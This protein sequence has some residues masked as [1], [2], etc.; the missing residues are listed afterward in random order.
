MNGIHDLGGMDGLGPIEPQEDEPVFAADWERR[1]FALSVAMGGQM[2]FTL[3][4]WRHLREQ[5][6]PAVYLE[7]GYYEHWLLVLERQVIDEGLI[8][9]AEL[10]ARQA[11]LAAGDA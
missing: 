5:I 6:D 11:Q 9:R 7:A 8:T 10:E 2:R 3:D 4:E 1:V